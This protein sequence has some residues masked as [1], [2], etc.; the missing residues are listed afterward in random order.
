MATPND[1]QQLLDTHFEQFHQPDFIPHDPISI[2]HR[3][4]KKQ[5]IEISGFIAAVLAWG[6][7]KTIINKCTELMERMDN[8]PHDFILHHQSADLKKLLGFKHRTFNEEDLLYFV[9]FLKYCYKEHNSLEEWFCLKDALDAPNI[10]R[11]LIYFNEAFTQRDTF[12]QRTG[13]HVATPAR[14]SACKRINMYLRWMVRSA[15]GGVDFG[16]WKKISPAQLIC[17]CDVHVDRIARRLDLLTRKQTDWLAAVE[18]TENL[19][20]FDPLDPV[21]YDLAL[22]GIGVNEK[23]GDFEL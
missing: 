10:E 16:L 14:K 2:P 19:K 13:K 17:P 18:L 11:G 3:F 7:R 15:E 4:R 6:Q 5:D 12:P 22:F 9:D 1:L 23:N 8:A 21:K 20:A